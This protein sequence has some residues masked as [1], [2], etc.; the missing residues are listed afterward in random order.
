MI[1]SSFQKNR[2]K[3]DKVSNKGQGGILKGIKTV[4]GQH[5]EIKY[6]P[7]IN[8]GWMITLVIA[9]WR[10]T[11]VSVIAPALLQLL[12]NYNPFRF[13]DLTGRKLSKAARV[14]LMS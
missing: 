11:C 12:V 2:Q 9:H 8:P 4:P 5:L 7:R 3:E 1:T 10:S 14:N 13:S 6:C